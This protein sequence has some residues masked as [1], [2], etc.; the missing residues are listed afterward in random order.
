MVE[1]ADG[2]GGVSFPVVFFDGEC[3]TGIGNVVIHEATDFKAFQSMLSRKIGI[4]PHQ[5]S[6]YIADSDNSH[7]RVP[8]TGK[9]N[10]SAVSRE[11]GCIFLVVLK[12][13]QRYATRKGKNKEAAPRPAA[14]TMMKKEP[15]PNVVLLRRGAGGGDNLM[16]ARVFTGLDEFERRVRDLQMEKERYLVNLGMANLRIERES[17][18]LVCE[19]CENAKT[20]GRDVG[21]HRCVYD[22][23]TF[24]FRS[25]AGPIAPPGKGHAMH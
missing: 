23:V 18:S 13:S 6:I 20:V 22:S 24:G 3:E 2:A 10:F 14:A 21:F 25:Y 9:V 17:K 12:R 1:A 11:T 5:F 4:S 16:D 8:V 19:D 15:P 7:N